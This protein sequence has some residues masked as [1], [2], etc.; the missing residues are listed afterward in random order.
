MS[1]PSEWLIKHF[2]SGVSPAN[3]ILFLCLFSAEES[4]FKGELREQETMQWLRLIANINSVHFFLQGKTNVQDPQQTS[5]QMFNLWAL[6]CL[7]AQLW[8]N[9]RFW[10]KYFI[11][12][13]L[14]CGILINGRGLSPMFGSTLGQGKF[15]CLVNTSIRKPSAFF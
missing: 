14:S 9:I 1:E 7:R 12:T 13:K 3:L 10:R 8:L 5:M 4:S 6:T 11:I 15:H 2:R